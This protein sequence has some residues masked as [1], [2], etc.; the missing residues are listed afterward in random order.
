MDAF[1]QLFFSPNM[2]PLQRIWDLGPQALT[3]KLLSVGL[4]KGDWGIRVRAL[5]L[6]KLS[7]TMT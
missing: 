5:G 6:I 1:S 3:R 4:V 7:L 2:V